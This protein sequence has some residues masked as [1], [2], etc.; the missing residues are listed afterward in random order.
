MQWVSIYIKRALHPIT[1][2][3]VTGPTPLKMIQEV[4]TL[5]L[6]E[7]ANTLV[8]LY[9]GQG[10]VTAYLDIVCAEEIGSTSKIQSLSDNYHYFAFL[11]LSLTLMF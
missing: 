9:L 8:K 2:H 3:Q 7:L 11:I 10:K 4:M 6:M 5:D 1:Q